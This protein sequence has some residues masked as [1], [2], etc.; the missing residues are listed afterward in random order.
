MGAAVLADGRPSGAMLRRVQGALSLRNEFDKV[1]YVPSGGTKAK[2]ARSEAEMMRLL[3]KQA[4]VSDDC[5]VTESLSKSTLESVMNCASIVGRLPK[6]TVIVSTDT[7]HV[8]RSRLLLRMMGIT[9]AFR[10]MPSGR[11]ANGVLRWGFY[12]F[13]ECV[14]T[15]VDVMLLLFT[16]CRR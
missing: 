15:P 8:H 12:Y 16:R 9:T 5:I 11:S 7:Y 6:G 13:R 10:P 3:L 4:G 1:F 2:N 14:A